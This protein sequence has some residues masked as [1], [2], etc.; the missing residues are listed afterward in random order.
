MLRL[1]DLS[2]IFDESRPVQSIDVLQ[3][4]FCDRQRTNTLMLREINDNFIGGESHPDVALMRLRHKDTHK[5]PEHQMSVQTTH[6]L[7]ETSHHE[8][9]KVQ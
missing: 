8:F 1:I 7:C 3:E 5:L 4:F 6:V 9:Q 2:M